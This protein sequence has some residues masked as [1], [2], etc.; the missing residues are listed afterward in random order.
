MIWIASLSVQNALLPWLSEAPGVDLVFI[1][2]GIR[3]ILVMIGG[4]WAALGLTLGS[5]LMT[6]GEFG[7]AN[8]AAI[9]SIALCT[10][11]CPFL[12]LRVTQRLIGIGPD[13]HE[14]RAS[15]LPIL[16]LGVAL[17]SSLL[18]N[19]LFLGVGLTQL[20]QFPR[21]VLAMATGDFTGSLIAVVVFWAVLRWRRGASP[22]R[23]G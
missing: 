7:T 12:S 15:H 3:L 20:A 21:H 6:G 2:A 18:H 4:I 23:G 8:L 14:L 19:L 10:G 1:P 16:S 9:I 22:T 5:L 13:L 17:G 11:F